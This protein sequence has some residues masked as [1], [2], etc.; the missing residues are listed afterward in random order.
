MRSWV[1][2]DDDAAA[3]RERLQELVELLGVPA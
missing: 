3:R 1:S 2:V